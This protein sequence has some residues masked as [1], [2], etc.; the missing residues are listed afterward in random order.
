MIRTMGIESQKDL[1]IL[2]VGISIIVTR[3]TWMIRTMT[4]VVVVRRNADLP[5]QQLPPPLSIH[6]KPHVKSHKH[7][8]LAIA[9][10]IQI[11]MYRN[12]HCTTV[13]VTTRM[14]QFL[15][16][17]QYPTRIDHNN[18]PIFMSPITHI[19]HRR[20]RPPLSYVNH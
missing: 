12:H 15:W 3:I 2:I 14:K 19:N 17:D 4:I 7:M 8:S 13:Q 16:I 18:P 9:M 20:H 1:P 11:S 5:Q 6:S 10:T